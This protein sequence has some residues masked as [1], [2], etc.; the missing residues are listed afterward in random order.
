MQ[1]SQLCPIQNDTILD[2]LLKPFH[3]HRRVNRSQCPRIHQSGLWYSQERG[4]RLKQKYQYAKNQYQTRSSTAR[5]VA[6][7]KPRPAP[8]HYRRGKK[9]IVVLWGLGYAPSRMR[10][11]TERSSRI[12]FFS[13]HERRSAHSF[14]SCIDYYLFNYREVA[15]VIDLAKL[16]YLV[17][18]PEC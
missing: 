14:C 1:G 15:L 18:L 3:I 8:S 12:P 17:I 9:S 5:D 13:S 4:R 10:G 7:Y 2:F 11:S 6:V 16:S